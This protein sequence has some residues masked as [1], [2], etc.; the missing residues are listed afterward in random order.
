MITGDS[1]LTSL[2]VAKKVHICNT[3]LPV[4]TLSLRKVVTSTTITT[5]SDGKLDD[6][7]NNN[8]GTTSSNLKTKQYSFDNFA[9]SIYDEASNKEILNYLPL[10][11]DT[12]TTTTSTTKG[13]SNTIPSLASKYNLVTTEE[14]FL[15]AI[16]ASGGKTSKLW[17]YAGELNTKR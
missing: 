12:S 3:S 9:W 16:N 4:L 11:L 15:L 2:H 17:N 10:V 14:T 7:S 6:D 5:A 1:L 13:D 8:N